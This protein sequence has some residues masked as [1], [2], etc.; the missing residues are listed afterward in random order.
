MHSFARPQSPDKP[1]IFPYSIP[2]AGIR[3][4]QHCSSRSDLDIMVLPHATLPGY[5]TLDAGASLAAR[6]T[7]LT[8][9][10]SPR[11]ACLHERNGLPSVPYMRHIPT[12]RASGACQA[13]RSIAT[14]AFHRPTED[15]IICHRACQQPFKTSI[16]LSREWMAPVFCLIPTS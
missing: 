14:R 3:C 6:R 15:F 4:S 10:A 16:E 1:C 13:R 9:M 8:R 2:I 11:P 12:V 5:S 7:R